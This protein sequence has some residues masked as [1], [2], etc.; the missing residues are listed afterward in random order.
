MKDFFKI[1]GYAIM[2]F[3]FLDFALSWVYPDPLYSWYYFTYD[4]LGELSMGT[5]IVLYFIGQ[6]IVG[7]SSKEEEIEQE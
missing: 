1:L 7:L 4:L 2:G 3:A 5:P 6:F